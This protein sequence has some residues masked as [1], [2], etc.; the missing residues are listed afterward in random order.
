MNSSIF[1]VEIVGDV[2]FSVVGDKE[3]S[4]V[5]FWAEFPKVRSFKGSNVFLVSVW[6]RK[7]VELIKNQGFKIGDSLLVAGSLALKTHASVNSKN[8]YVELSVSR[9]YS[10]SY[11]S[12]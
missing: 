8:K 1:M 10:S 6:G 7:Q 5:Q 12:A 2:R 9:V 11:L 3:I 4:L